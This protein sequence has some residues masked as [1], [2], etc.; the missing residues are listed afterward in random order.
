MDIV[1]IARL[2]LLV[3]EAGPNNGQRVNGIQMWSG[4]K[5]ALGSSWCAWFVTMVMDLFFQGKSPIPRQGGVQAIRTLASQQGW[6]A[7]TPS[8]GDLY[9]YVDTN[10]HGHHIGFVTSVDPLEG[11]AGNTS[12]DGTSSNG[13]RV[14][15]HG[16][17]AGHGTI[18]FVHY[19]S[20]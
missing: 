15:E 3:R 19:P 8:V 11:I 14:A 17:S 18:E 5:D 9:I 6:I 12:A 20:P 4:G 2:F 13:D 16:I 7:D 10:D 1:Q